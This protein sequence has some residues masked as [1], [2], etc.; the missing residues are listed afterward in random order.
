MWVKKCIEM[1]EMLFKITN[2]TPPNLFLNPFKSN[3]FLMSLSFPTRRSSDLTFHVF[4]HIFSPTRISTN[5]FKQQFLVFK[6][7]YQMDPKTTYQFTSPKSHKR[8]NF[9]QNLFFFFFFFII[10]CISRCARKLETKLK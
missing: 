3:M 10:G 4:S 5:I 8:E 9:V 7:K 6:H 2:Q 1:R